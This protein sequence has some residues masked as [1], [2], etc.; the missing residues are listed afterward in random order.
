MLRQGEAVTHS[1]ALRA[2]LLTILSLTLAT[3]LFAASAG[4][5]RGKVVG[6]D[7]RPMA[8][9]LVVLRNDVTGFRQQAASGTE[10]QF[11]FFNVPF[12]PYELHVEVQGFATVHQEVDIH[13]VIP[14]HTTVKL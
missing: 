11:S 13:S 9:V 12:N 8:G 7:N 10:G 2:V 5:L 4:S 3:S 1:R 6:P 14:L